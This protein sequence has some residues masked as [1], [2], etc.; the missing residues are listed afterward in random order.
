MQSRSRRLNIR[1]AMEARRGERISLT[2]LHFPDRRPA[3]ACLSSGLSHSARRLCRMRAYGARGGWTNPTKTT[4]A[5]TRTAMGIRYVLMT[6][7]VGQ[8]RAAV[9][10]TKDWM[11]LGAEGSRPS[12]RQIEA[13][14]DGVRNALAA[15]AC[16]GK[17]IAE[18]RV[19]VIGEGRPEQTPGAVETCFHG[20][21]TKTQ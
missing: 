2:V 10:F 21:R 16:E 19:D 6:S 20:F 8:P 13:P 1:L 9:C 17:D 5:V 18:Q 11:L 4:S 7:V 12:A 15:P 3:N 14:H